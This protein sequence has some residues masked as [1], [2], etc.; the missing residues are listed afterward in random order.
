VASIVERQGYDGLALATAMAG[1]I[2]IVAVLLRIRGYIRYI[3]H[4]VIVGFAAGIAV[5]I[6]ASQISELL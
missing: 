3:P 6:A 1:V 5:I 2:M 4:P